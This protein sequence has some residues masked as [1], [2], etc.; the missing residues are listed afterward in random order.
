MREWRNRQTRTCEGRVVIPYGFKSR[1]SHQKADELL[2]CLLFIST[3]ILPTG[4]EP[5]SPSFAKRSGAKGTYNCC[6][7]RQAQL[8]VQVSSLAPKSRGT[9]QSVC[10]LFFANLFSTGLEP[11]SPYF[12]KQTTTWQGGGL[13]PPLNH[14]KLTVTNNYIFI[15]YR[16]G[17]LCSPIF[18]LL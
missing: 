18:N 7:E 11:V 15:L 17:E 5:V 9:F 14:N 2:V 16:R 10:F 13:L 6:R 1:L 4:L 12:A 3:D 8:G